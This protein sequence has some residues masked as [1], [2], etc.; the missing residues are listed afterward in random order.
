M[1]LGRA[2]PSG[3]RSKVDRMPRGYNSTFRT[4]VLRQLK[5]YLTFTKTVTKFNLCLASGTI[6][7][8]NQLFYWPILY[9]NQLFYWPI[10]HWNTFSSYFVARQFAAT[11]TGWW[12]V[13]HDLMCHDQYMIIY[14]Y[15]YLTQ[16]SSPCTSNFNHCL[17]PVLTGKCYPV[18]DWESM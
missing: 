18:Y 8:S 6:L 10:S 17:V 13:Y 12:A 5:S 4:C 2:N 15:G 1:H 16:N 11:I 9:S 7:Y 14:G 3:V